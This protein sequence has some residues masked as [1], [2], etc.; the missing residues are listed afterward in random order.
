MGREYVRLPQPSMPNRLGSGGFAGASSRRKTHGLLENPGWESPPA[1][2]AGVGRPPRA[3][4]LEAPIGWPGRPPVGAECPKMPTRSRRRGTGSSGGGKVATKAWA[5]SPRRTDPS[6]RTREGV[7]APAAPCAPQP[8][9][10]SRSKKWLMAR[11]RGSDGTGTPDC[12]AGASADRRH[13]LLRTGSLSRSRNS[14]PQIRVAR[15]AKRWREIRRDVS[16]GKAFPSVEIAMRTMF[17]SGV[18]TPADFQGVRVGL[19]RRPAPDEGSRQG[20]VVPPAVKL[21]ST[22]AKRRRKGIGA[23]ARRPPRV[24]PRSGHNRSAPWHRIHRLVAGYAGLT[25]ARDGRPR[26]ARRPATRCMKVGTLGSFTAR[27]HG[28]RGRTPSREGRERP[29]IAARNSR[30]AEARESVGPGRFTAD[31]RSLAAEPRRRPSAG[32]KPRSRSSFNQ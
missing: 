25:T 9:Q 2:V 26:R 22:H 17:G 18:G 31:D 15:G 10:Q 7:L 20:P 8:R 29:E 24:R 12:A 23:T 14:A 16:R 32:P 1:R 19:I 11:T 21:A 30:R 6:A 3:V 5:G 28:P 13:G 4:G 27:N